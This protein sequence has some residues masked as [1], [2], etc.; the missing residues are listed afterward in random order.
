M[1][2][3]IYKCTNP[4]VCGLPQSAGEYTYVVKNSNFGKV[5]VDTECQQFANNS[6]Y[7]PFANE[8]IDLKN[9]PK[10]LFCSYEKYKDYFKVFIDMEDYLIIMPEINKNCYDKSDV[11]IINYCESFH[12]NKIMLAKRFSKASLVGAAKR[13]I[14]HFRSG[15]YSLI[16]FDFY[17]NIA[18]R[19]FDI[20]SKYFNV[21]YS[22]EVLDSIVEISRNFVNLEIYLNSIGKVLDLKE[23]EI[24][25]SIAKIN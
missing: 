21:N 24:D 5:F 18:N 7:Y 25:S 11:I 15:S 19:K 22:D 16:D 23:T 20:I 1:S 9:E 3:L 13:G 12:R 6:Y 14:E 10:E 4:E 2:E 8:F 17:K